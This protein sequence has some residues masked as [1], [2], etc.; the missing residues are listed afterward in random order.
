[1]RYR[2][3]TLAFLFIATA[4]AARAQFTKTIHATFSARGIERVDLGVVDSVTVE[5]W[6]GDMI[7]IQSD[8]RV[9]QASESLFE[10]LVGEA[11]RYGVI[12]SREGATLHLLSTEPERRTI[13]ARAGTVREEVTVKVLLP[14]EFTGEGRG[15]YVRQTDEHGR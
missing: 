4:S 11:D 13:Q 1:M 8:V 2:L 15:P 12:S 7:L 3:P 10:Y 14:E 6:A 9:Y 5:P